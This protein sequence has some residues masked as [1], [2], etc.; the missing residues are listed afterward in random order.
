MSLKLLMEIKIKVS[1]LMAF[2]NKLPELNKELFDKVFPNKNIQSE[3]EFRSAISELLAKI[4]TK[5]A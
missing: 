1:L 5:L 4:I 2:N 3:E